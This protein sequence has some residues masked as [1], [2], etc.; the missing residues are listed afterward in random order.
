MSEGVE[1]AAE[2]SPDEDDDPINHLRAQCSVI[3]SAV[4]RR[5][6]RSRTADDDE[7]EPC[8]DLSM[9]QALLAKAHASVRLPPCERDPEVLT[10]VLRCL[11]NGALLHDPSELAEA[12][13]L[14]ALVEAAAGSADVFAPP[15]TQHV[16]MMLL[17]NLSRAASAAPAVACLK[18]M[19]EGL[20][21]SD[22]P[23]LRSLSS[24]VLKNLSLHG[25]GL[26]ARLSLPDKARLQ[27]VTPATMLG[28]ISRLESGV[29]TA[30]PPRTPQ[31]TRIPGRIVDATKAEAILSSPSAV[32]AVEAAEAKAVGEEFS[33]GAGGAGEGLADVALV[34]QLACALHPWV[35]PRLR[36]SAALRLARLLMLAWKR[37]THDETLLYLL[38]LA[39]ALHGFGSESAAALR[40]A[41]PPNGWSNDGFS[42]AAA[43]ACLFCLAVLPLLG[44]GATV[45]GRVVLDRILPVVQPPTSLTHPVRVRLA[46]ASLQNASSDPRAASCFRERGKDKGMRQKLVDTLWAAAALPHAAA[47][48]LALGTI[49]NLAA[50]AT[51]RSSAD[52]ELTEASFALP[53]VMPEPAAVGT[54]HR[55]PPPAL[56]LPPAAASPSAE[57]YRALPRLCVSLTS[58][59]PH[60]A[61]R[62]ALGSLVVLLSSRSLDA[63]TALSLLS[64]YGCVD[65]LVALATAPS[66]AKEDGSA[67]ALI[68]D[69]ALVL[70]GALRLVYGLGGARLVAPHLSAITPP[71]IAALVSTEP[72][73]R[74]AAAF[75]WHD[76]TAAKGPATSLARATVPAGKLAG[77][78]IPIGKTATGGAPAFCSGLGVMRRLATSAPDASPADGRLALLA[79]GAVS[80]VLQHSSLSHLW[81]SAPDSLSYLER[82]S[83]EEAAELVALPISLAKEGVMVMVEGA[84]VEGV[85]VP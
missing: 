6:P 51:A 40:T 25:G 42:E 81:T 61:L 46:L 68:R 1:A 13:G 4:S 37:G 44:G 65:R 32:A 50:V 9:V 39:Y 69:A 17:L 84:A 5:R 71:A 36:E 26:I 7:A 77:A 72:R 29:S 16:A 3:E 73:A 66:E 22:D 20:G 78:G 35:S 24:A 79:A 80:H 27:Q 2:S 10:L 30:S 58:H 8:F 19:L 82:L 38:E 67:K 63:A 43:Q 12:D 56:P 49:A 18:P 54:F 34:P 15:T 62:R 14:L 48:D 31:N 59:A 75:F 28:T 74:M 83:E 23:R 45:F 60:A 53:L 64:A 21:R 52:E 41:A 33:A 57:G 70:L 85:S 11:A 76:A 47:S 55:E